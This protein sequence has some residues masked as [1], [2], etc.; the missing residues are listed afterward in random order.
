MAAA[1]FIEQLNKEFGTTP[2]KIAK[3]RLP[4]M[5]EKHSF[6]FVGVDVDIYYDVSGSFP[7]YQ[8]LVFQGARRAEKILK[9]WGFWTAKPKST[10]AVKRHRDLWRARAAATKDNRE[11]ESDDA[12]DALSDVR[13]D[14][15]S[16]SDSAAPAAAVFHNRAVLGELIFLSSSVRPDICEAAHSAARC[17]FPDLQ[18]QML[19]HLLRYLRGTLELGVE[20]H[21]NSS[22][23]YLRVYRPLWN[24]QH[25]GTEF[26]PLCVF[27]DAGFQQCPS[28]F[29]SVTGTLVTLHG[30]AISWKSKRQST[31]TTS[32]PHAETIAAVDSI[33]HA[34][35]L[36][37][38]SVM[39]GT[40]C[41]KE[42]YAP[43][44]PVFGDNLP[45]L[46]AAEKGFKSP[47]TR[48]YSG[49][50][51]LLGDLVDR[52]SHASTKLLR[53]DGLT[54]V[55]C[56]NLIDLLISGPRQL[57]AAGDVETRGERRVTFTELK[58]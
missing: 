22:R 16:P 51:F 31:C 40:A 44:P 10:P 43:L 50:L 35:G 5:I 32:T 49:R 14:F 46:Q 7:R 6:D 9:K 48:H 18:A 30:V 39:P 17:P 41:R 52:I 53:A 15:D 2:M 27:S 38:V 36:A 11:V 19:K 8:R 26:S 47:A 21:A 54:K 29:R 45:S 34:Q 24:K 57:G 56:Q 58:D 12:H 13:T 37:I 42:G 20:W 25:P 28:T 23:D 3:T 4:G 33:Y 55:A 1:D